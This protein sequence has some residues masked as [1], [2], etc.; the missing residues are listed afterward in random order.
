MIYILKKDCLINNMFNKNDFRNKTKS[1]N[2]KKNR[3]V[4]WIVTVVLKTVAEFPSLKMALAE[5][6]CEHVADITWLRDHMI[7]PDPFVYKIRG[8]SF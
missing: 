4:V 2:L 5:T 6:P 8:I 1:Q 3:F 7:T